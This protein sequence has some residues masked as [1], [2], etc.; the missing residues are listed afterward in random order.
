M[1]S[2]V[3]IIENLSKEYVLGGE[4]T[5]QRTFREM[6]M[7]AVT[8]PMKRLRRLQ[9]RSEQQERFW[10]L[11]DVSFTVNEGEVVG[12]IGANGAGK[13][14][15]L[16]VL[17]RIT[18]PTEGHIQYKGRIASLLEVG[19]G[20]HP[21]LSGRENIFI[22]GA[23]LGMTKSEITKRFDEIVEFSGVE[24]FLDTPVKRYSSGMYVRLA[25]AVA[26]HMDPDI[27]I[28][29]EVLA[30]GDAAFQKKCICMMRD[31]SKQGR[32][33]LF[34]SHNMNMIRNLCT[35][36]ISLSNG[37]IVDEGDVS[38]VINSYIGIEKSENL[39]IKKSEKLA[40]SYQS[41]KQVLIKNEM[42]EETKHISFSDRAVVEIKYVAPSGHDSYIV[43][44]RITDSF[45]NT[46]FTSWDNDFLKDRN[47]KKGKEYVLNCTIPNYLLR[48]G[49]YV[50][51]AFI[52]EQAHGIAG[53]IEE[54]EVIFE[55]TDEGCI[56]NKNRLGIIAPILEWKID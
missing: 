34:V 28:V 26:A 4:V 45:G 43:A 14:T 25:F 55:V 18:A 9:G 32:T 12:I 35:R 22:N 3:I 37:K 33:V 8:E 27:L 50:V 29:D 31:V 13:S 53:K 47:T 54:I 51:T 24:K 40:D 10:A 41:L 19:T 11:K 56:L 49:K 6:L 7:G 44:V 42:G 15:L 39:L 21:E 1:S 46:L 48:P 2:P 52:R 23:I 30:V 36:A 38:N 20:F 5:E 17:S 16:K